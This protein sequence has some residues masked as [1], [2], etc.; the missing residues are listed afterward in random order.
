MVTMTAKC[1]TDYLLQR[2]IVS[3][4]FVRIDYN[5]VFRSCQKKKKK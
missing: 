1:T 5:Y 4:N 3:K 2:T